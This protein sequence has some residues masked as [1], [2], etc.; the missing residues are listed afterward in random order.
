[1]LLQLQSMTSV[2]LM[3]VLLNEF[4]NEEEMNGT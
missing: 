3:Y 2:W 4:L 1:M